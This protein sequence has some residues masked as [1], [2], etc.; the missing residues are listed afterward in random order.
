MVICCSVAHGY[1][2]VVLMCQRVRSL[3]PKRNKLSNNTVLKINPKRRAQ[4]IFSVKKYVGI[5]F[6]ILFN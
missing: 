6:Y 3:A 5:L 1:I 2:I 4:V